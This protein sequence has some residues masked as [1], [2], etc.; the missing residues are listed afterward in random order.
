M[1][2]PNTIKVISKSLKVIEGTGFQLL[3]NLRLI[4][5]SPILLVRDNLIS[6]PSRHMKSKQGRTNIEATSWR[7]LHVDMTLFLGRVP[8]G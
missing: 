3:T 6:L 2:L 1:T 5:I 8:D 7:R 4:I